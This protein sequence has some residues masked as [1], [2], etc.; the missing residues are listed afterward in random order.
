MT[1]RLLISAL[2]LTALLAG[3]GDEHAVA[4]D[5]DNAMLDG[6]VFQRPEFIDTRPVEVQRQFTLTADDI[7][8]LA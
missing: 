3:C 6:S 5:L 8:H 7:F 1:K 2:L 4:P